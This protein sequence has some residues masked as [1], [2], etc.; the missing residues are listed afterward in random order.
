MTHQGVFRSA[1]LDPSAARPM[2]M[3]SELVDPVQNGFQVA[4]G[5]NLR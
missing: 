4:V 3:T 1:A 5:V 2:P